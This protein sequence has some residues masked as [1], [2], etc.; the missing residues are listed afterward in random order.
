MFTIGVVGVI[1]WIVIRLYVV[2][3]NVADFLK[4]TETNE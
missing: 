3:I 1:T 4:E 2:H